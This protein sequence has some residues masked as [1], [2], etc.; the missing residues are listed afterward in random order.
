MTVSLKLSVTAGDAISFFDPTDMAHAP[1]T[2]MRVLETSANSLIIPVLI[3]SGTPQ[4]LIELFD[5]SL[6]FDYAGFD[7]INPPY[8]MY[9]NG[10]QTNIRA[11]SFK[12]IGTLEQV[13]GPVAPSD[14]Q[15]LFNSTT[16]Q[17]RF[18]KASLS[19]KP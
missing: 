9:V 14:G 7:N 16:A 19:Y 8:Y 3:E 13:Q 12:P 1:V 18:L 17:A 4:T 5:I 10:N 15:G 6:G 2:V 11:I